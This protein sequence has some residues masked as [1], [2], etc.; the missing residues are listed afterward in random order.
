[1]P[2]ADVTA[3][4]PSLPEQQRRFEQ[5]IL[6][7]ELI[8]AIL[9]RMRVGDLPGWYLSGGCLFQTVWNREHGYSATNGILDYDL[10]YLP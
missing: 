3:G 6:G 10:F 9:G 7:N 8:A 4:L 2:S 1:M 5:T